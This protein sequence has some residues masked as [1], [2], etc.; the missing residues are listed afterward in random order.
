MAF[1]FL[2]K[3]F[4]LKVIIETNLYLLLG[5]FFMKISKLF[6]VL[7]SLFIINNSQCS[8]RNAQIKRNYQDYVKI[9]QEWANKY[10]GLK[11]TYE[12]S[13]DFRIFIETENYD[14]SKIDQAKKNNEAFNALNNIRMEIERDANSG[15][16]TKHEKT[17]LCNFMTHSIHPPCNFWSF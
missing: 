16:I 2:K 1:E 11:Y 5:L 13:C 9:I 12:L 10:R 8:D 14:P 7:I 3:R 6:L 4:I 17:Y 15:S